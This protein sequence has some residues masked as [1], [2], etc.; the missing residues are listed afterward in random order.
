V[1]TPAGQR[2]DDK[3]ARI[4]SHKVR[5]LYLSH[6]TDIQVAGEHESIELAL[7]SGTSSVWRGRAQQERLL[8]SEACL[9][10]ALWEA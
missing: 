6:F 5:D 7:F 10:E 4:I 3:E 2:P 1:T 9:N 8:L